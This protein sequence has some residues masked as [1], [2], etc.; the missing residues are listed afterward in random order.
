MRRL[1]CRVVIGEGARARASTTL[2]TLDG[3]LSNLD[4]RPDAMVSG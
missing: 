2:V 4:A 3:R 1:S